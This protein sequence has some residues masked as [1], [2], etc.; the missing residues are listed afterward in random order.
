MNGNHR[1]TVEPVSSKFHMLSSFV[2]INVMLSIELH[3]Y[4][5]VMLRKYIHDIIFSHNS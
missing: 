1:M 2:K 3:N 4:V 5:I